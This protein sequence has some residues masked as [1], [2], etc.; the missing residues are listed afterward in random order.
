[1]RPLHSWHTN[2]CGEKDSKNRG[3]TKSLR[4]YGRPSLTGIFPLPEEKFDGA[5]LRTRFGV[6]RVRILAIHALRTVFSHVMRDEERCSILR[7][8]NWDC[9]DL[10]V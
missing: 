8:E 1:M 3:V 7:G 4:Q 9:Y 5:Q 10:K 2:L 6:R